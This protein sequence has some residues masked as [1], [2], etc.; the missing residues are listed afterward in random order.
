M[1]TQKSYSIPTNP[2]LYDFW[3]KSHRPSFVD[4]TLLATLTTYTSHF[5]RLPKLS[6]LLSPLGKGRTHLPTDLPSPRYVNT[7]NEKAPH[8]ERPTAVHRIVFRSHLSSR[9]GIT[10]PRWYTMTFISGFVRAVILS[11]LP[12]NPSWTL[13]SSRA[14]RICAQPESCEINAWERYF[15]KNYSYA[16]SYKWR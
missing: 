1:I 12:E 4:R 10:L 2:I 3:K 9:S 13:L 14:T 7:R 6:Y 16:L 8:L 5:V 15:L 11:L